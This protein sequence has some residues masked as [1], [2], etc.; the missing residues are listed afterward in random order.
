M[1]GQALRRT[2]AV[3][4]TAVA[5]AIG[6]ASCSDGPEFADRSAVVKVGSAGT[7]YR[8]TSCGLDGQTVFLVAETPDGAVLQAVLGL[9]DDGATGVSASTGVT[10][11]EDPTATDSRSA[12]FGPEAWDR[13]GSAGD[14]P[15]TVTAAALRGSRIQFSGTIDRVDAQDQVLPNTD[16]LPFSVDAR[17]DEAES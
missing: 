13:R 10:I 7:S 17:C 5:L 11:D 2:V 6:L 9:A 14:P 12:A 15:G 4:A 8:V 1:I 3:L 16:P